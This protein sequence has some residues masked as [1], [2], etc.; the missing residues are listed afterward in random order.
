MKPNTKKLWLC[1][2]IPLLIGGVA[3]LLTRSGTQ[4]Y[5]LMAKP[6]L[7]PPGWLFPVV[8]TVLYIMMGLA[9]YIVYSSD[10]SPIRKERALSFYA[11][12]LGL[13]FF[14]PLIFFRLEM[15]LTALL[16]LAALWVLVWIC[17]ALFYH[18]RRAAFYLLLPYGLWCTF[19]LYLNFSVYLRN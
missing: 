11:V 4:S 14:W 9:S 8:W 19:A 13:N 15:F 2:A 1:I 17:A 6:P 10:A 16:W 18:I 3:G 7:S 12:Q 5:A